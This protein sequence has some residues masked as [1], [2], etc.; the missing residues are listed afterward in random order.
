MQSMGISRKYARRKGTMSKQSWDFSFVLI[1][2]QIVNSR[3]DFFYL[4]T[5]LFLVYIQLSGFC[6]EQSVSSGTLRL[7]SV[8]VLIG[9]SVNKY[10][11]IHQKE[12]SPESD[13][14]KTS[15]R[16]ELYFCLNQYKP[17]SQKENPW[18]RLTPKPK[19]NCKS[20][21]WF[22]IG[23]AVKTSKHNTESPEKCII[24]SK[25]QKQIT[26]QNQYYTPLKSNP[27]NPKPI[28]TSTSKT[29]L[30]KWVKLLFLNCCSTQH[31]QAKYQNPT[32]IQ[33]IKSKTQ[34]QISPKTKILIRVKLLVLDWSSTQHF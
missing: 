3:A 14:S 29:K 28:N 25:T 6:F 1:E 19:H 7:Y 11:L 27:R 31:F 33:S 24:K 23:A 15:L 17:D 30:S 16:T 34:K 9:F 2:F 8:Y 4:V 5:Y 12:R 10:H 21:F 26:A 13:Q 32:K 20:K 18:N 22:L